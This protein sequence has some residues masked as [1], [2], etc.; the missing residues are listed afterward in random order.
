MKEGFEKFGIVLLILSSVYLGVQT[1][2][3]C[4]SLK[5]EGI[6]QEIREEIVNKYELE[7]TNEDRINDTYH[8][9][10][11]F[12][13]K[14][15]E[16]VK[17][18]FYKIWLDV[19]YARK[20]MEKNGGL[21]A[22]KDIEIGFRPLIEAIA[23]VESGGRN[24][25]KSNK[26]AK[27][28]VQFRDALIKKYNINPYDVKESLKACEKEIKRLIGKYDNI[29]LAL[30][31]YN[32]G[33]KNVDRLLKKYKEKIIQKLP[34]QTFAFIIKVLSRDKILRKIYLSEYYK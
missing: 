11:Y 17:N 31:A 18:N 29:P 27:G 33:E 10:S 13:E 12:M 34:K 15:R 4:Y 26:G 7:K 2:R 24:Y 22:L 21:E 9:T 6:R 19:K 28:I 23:I 1:C 30:A 5:R 8:I 16:N 32:Y 14:A 20:N 3:G 25:V